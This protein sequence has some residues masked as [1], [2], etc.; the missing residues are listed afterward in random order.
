MC[1]IE[2]LKEMGIPLGPRKKIAKFVKE[3]VNKQVSL[4][5]DFE[6]S[7]CFSSQTNNNQ[8]K[9]F[10]PIMLSCQAAQEKKAEVKD[11]SQVVAPP[12][13]E[14]LPDPA[15]KKLPVGR[16]VSSVHVDYNYF[17]VGTGQVNDLQHI[18]G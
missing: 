11:V 17:E 14:A 15:V 1:T 16:T 8:H 13:A 5:P 3:R 6:G 2:D 18:E 7:L 12:A 4:S 9:L 10:F